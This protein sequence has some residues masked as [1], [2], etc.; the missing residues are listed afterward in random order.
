MT[1]PEAGPERYSVATATSLTAAGMMVMN[2]LLYLFTLAASR[3]LG[4]EEFRDICDQQNDGRLNLPDIPSGDYTVIQTQTS[5]GFDIAPETTVRV[6]AGETVELPL[7][8]EAT[9]TGAEQEATASA[10]ETPETPAT[11]DGGLIVNLRQEDLKDDGDDGEIGGQ[12]RDIIL[13]G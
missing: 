7:V 5:E 10:T 11:G 4:P 8:N 3:L 9:G 12:L 6:V 1:L 13:I 2:V